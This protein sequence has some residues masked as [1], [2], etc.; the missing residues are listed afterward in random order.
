MIYV[1]FRSFQGMNDLSQWR[2]SIG[3]FTSRVNSGQVIAGYYHTVTAVSSSASD[4]V[5]LELY[6]CDSYVMLLRT[7]IANVYECVCCSRLYYTV[8]SLWLWGHS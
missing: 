3:F 2:A 6:S 7:Y 1:I 5:L 4:V 8:A